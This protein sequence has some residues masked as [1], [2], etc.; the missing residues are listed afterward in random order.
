[1]HETILSYNSHMTATAHAL[2]A[3]AIATHFAA[4]EAAIPIALT[5]HF[6]MDSIP[7]WDFG[8]SWRNRSKTQTGMFAIAETLFGI[9]LAV[10]F[11]HTTVALP[12]LLLTIVAS[13]LPDW[14]EAPWYI[15]FAKTNTHGVSKKS[16]LLEKISY[17]FYKIPNIFHSRASLLLGVLTQVVTVWFF[18]AV[19]G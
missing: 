12:L 17:G 13:L 18:L 8:T 11:Y 7:H 9:S 15:F 3:G 14:L 10:F 6:I 16:G 4:P 19:L 1:M 2:V 5:S